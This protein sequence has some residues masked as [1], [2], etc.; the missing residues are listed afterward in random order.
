[1]DSIISGFVL[2]TLAGILVGLW[3]L[4]KGLKS[5]QETLAMA[6]FFASIISGAILGLVLCIPIA[7]IFAWQIKKKSAISTPENNLEQNT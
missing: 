3:P 5:N 4:L 6:G 1:M 2:G 7:W